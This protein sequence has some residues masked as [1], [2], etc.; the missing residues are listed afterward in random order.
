MA[1][2]KTPSLEYTL[3]HSP[4]SQSGVFQRTAS[5]CRASVTSFLFNCLINHLW[6]FPIPKTSNHRAPSPSLC[7]YTNSALNLLTL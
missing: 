5:V 3:G 4:F 6:L 7:N 1:A 2:P